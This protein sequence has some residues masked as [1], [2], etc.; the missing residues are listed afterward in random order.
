MN[1]NYPQPDPNQPWRYPDPAPMKP[2]KKRRWPWILGGAIAFFVV[3][4]SCSAATAPTTPEAAV[5]PVTMP[6]PAADQIPTP[7]VPEQV[8]PDL[9]AGGPGDTLVSEGLAVTAS[10]LTNTTWAGMSLTCSN[11]TYKNGSAE[12][13]SFNGLFDWKI[14]DPAGVIRNTSIGGDDALSAGQLAPGGTVSGNVCFDRGT[15]GEYT[16]T[17]EPLSLFSSESLTWKLTAK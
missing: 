16:L 7:T 17:M 15:A 2:A 10:P 4:G 5:S 13:K 6:P 14:Q 1:A 11:V 9:T 3:V 8:V 12:E